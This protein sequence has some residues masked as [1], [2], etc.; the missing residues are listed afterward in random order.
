MQNWVHLLCRIKPYWE[1][2]WMHIQYTADP[3][4]N[5]VSFP[6]DSE[7]NRWSH[8]TKM[9]QIYDRS[10]NA[11]ILEIWIVSTDTDIDMRLCPVL[12]LPQVCWDWKNWFAVFSSHGRRCQSGCWM[13]TWTLR[14][15]W[16]R[17]VTTRWPPSSSTPMLLSPISSSRRS[18]FKHQCIC[19]ICLQTCRIWSY[20]CLPSNT[21]G[22][23]CFS[24][25]PIGK[26]QVASMRCVQGL[27]SV[28]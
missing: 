28:K 8:F 7:T 20:S 15:C 4:I 26:I 25:L 22:D 9:T 19:Q 3:V 27:P 16:R 11:Y 17:S 21:Q 24:F 10:C 23:L 14:R 5:D 18:A 1:K 13:T 6:G 12:A 2:H